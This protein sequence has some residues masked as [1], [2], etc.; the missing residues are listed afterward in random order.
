MRWGIFIASHALNAWNRV[1]RN[2]KSIGKGLKHY[3]ERQTQHEIELKTRVLGEIKRLKSK[4]KEI[5]VIREL[6]CN[7]LKKYNRLGS[8]LELQIVKELQQKTLAN[9]NVIYEQIEPEVPDSSPKNLIDELWENKFS[10]M[11]FAN[12]K[13]MRLVTHLHLQTLEF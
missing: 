11:L 1:S 2:Q 13:I 7:R 10:N 6:V 3:C 9:E 5:D 4:G 12:G 8:K